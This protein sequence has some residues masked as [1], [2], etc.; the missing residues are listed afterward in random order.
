MTLKKTLAILVLA[1]VATAPLLARDRYEEKFERLEAL[2]ADGRVVLSNISGSIEVRSWNK[3][4]V[5]IDAVKFSESRS[6]AQAK[7]NAGEVTIEILREGSTLRIETRYPR[8]NRF[9]GG[10]NLNV[11]VDFKLWI[12]EKA[13]IDIKSISG[14]VDAEAVGGP[15]KIDTV[16]GEV[17]ARGAAAGI[18]IKVISG[19]VDVADV[20]GDAFL[21]T[22][23]GDIRV[24]K[25]RGSIEAETIS[26]ELDLLDVA[27]ARS[28]NAKTL[29]G[30]C[31]LSGRLVPQGRYT[32]KSHS[33]DVRLAIPADSAFDFEAE[34]F[35]GDI[36][37]D[38]EIQVSGK[39]SPREIRGTVKG[40]GAFVRMTTF[41]GS[42]ELRKN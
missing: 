25:V 10:D 18:G 8:R 29:S 42:I 12:P 27:D 19:D 36:D 26:G 11:W 22:V 30:N 21:K 38:F 5:K 33:G 13:G 28:V 40:G 4:E 20:A 15:L 6:E 32:L 34:T 35:S 23:S 7:E 3:A 9:W 1:T 24:S 16:S 37:T 31:V 41:S 14:D 17:V 2:A 39:V